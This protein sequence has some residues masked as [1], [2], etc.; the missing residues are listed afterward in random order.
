MKRVA[1]Y[2]SIVLSFLFLLVVS[3]PVAQA[4]SLKF[5]KT[6]VNVNAGETFDIGVVVDAGT[7][8]IHTTDAYVLYDSSLLEASGVTDGTFFPSVFNDITSQRVYIG[9]LV[10]DPATSKTGSGT[11]A[12]INFKALQSGTVTLSY[13]CGES[14]ETSQ[15]IKNDI[16]AT[17]IIT[18]SSN[19][20]ASVTVS[21][22]AVP[23]STPSALSPTPS[24]LPK[25]GVLD[26]LVKV[27]IPG[28]MLLVLGGI[29][30]L[31]LRI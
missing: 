24:E 9:G 28:I 20:T 22:A 7:D 5:D 18:C 1:V 26:N 15:V 3:A 13:I 8:S 30:K 21:G 2:F 10:D 31:F 16:N 19:G 29:L 23:T 11:I 25:T 12:T 27:A 4:A 6:T 17:D 14:G